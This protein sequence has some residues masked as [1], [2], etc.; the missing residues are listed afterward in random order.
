[1]T[2]AKPWPSIVGGHPYDPPMT[3][4]EQPLTCGCGTHELHDIAEIG[5]WTHG[6]L[7]ARRSQPKTVRAIA[8]TEP[9]WEW[10]DLPRGELTTLIAAAGGVTCEHALQATT[11]AD[12]S[13]DL[14]NGVHRW[15][16]CAELGIKRVPVRMAHV[17]DEP[18]W[19]WPPQ[20]LA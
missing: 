17:S 18:A 3:V 12:G 19:A 15:A 1:M 16:V 6:I 4:Q 20:G 11:L 5:E 13:I 14:G 2:R 7:G 9:I 10:S 8:E